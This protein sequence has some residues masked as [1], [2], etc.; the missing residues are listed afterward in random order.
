[1]AAVTDFFFCIPVQSKRIGGD[2]S[3]VEA[4]LDR[5][6]QSIYN[7]TD[8]DFTILVACHEI[9]DSRFAD[10]EN[11]HF[12]TVDH[13]AFRDAEIARADRNLKM[14]RCAAEIHQ[15]GGGYMFGVDYDDLVSNRIVQY[16]REHDHPYG[17]YMPRGFEGDAVA[18][19][20]WDLPAY[21]RLGPAFYQCCGTC[22]IFRFSADDLPSS[23][24]DTTPRTFDSFCSHHHVW[25]ERSEEL[26]RPLAPLPFPGTIYV[27]DPGMQ[28]SALT[29]ERGPRMRLNMVLG[30][31][32]PMTDAQVIEF[33]LGEPPNEAQTPSS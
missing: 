6:L 23:F 24:E 11:L 9:P 29:G 20:I 21:E 2:W 26:G 18:R 27:A 10:R 32:R 28:M 19:V 17:Y 1:L 7:Q 14:R 31:R 8:Q 30:H 12:L 4:V 13:P 33:G 3:R 15:R 22:A 5:T 16:V 25:K